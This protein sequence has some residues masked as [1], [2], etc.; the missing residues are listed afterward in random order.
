MSTP[1]LTTAPKMEATIL[2]FRTG[3]LRSLELSHGRYVVRPAITWDE[4][5]AALRLRFAIFNV[6]LGEGVAKSFA[7]GKDEDVFDRNANM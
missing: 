4:I 3:D 2:P 5:D 1:T 6:E 7:N